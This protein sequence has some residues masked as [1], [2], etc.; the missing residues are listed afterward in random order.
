MN[1]KCRV[2]RWQHVYACNSNNWFD[3]RLVVK[4]LVMN[5][6]CSYLGERKQLR[7]AWFKSTIDMSWTKILWLLLELDLHKWSNKYAC[8]NYLWTLTC[9]YT[10]YGNNELNLMLF[11]G[12][13]P[14][15]VLIL[16]MF[17]SKLFKIRLNVTMN[18][19][20]R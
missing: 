8:M 1:W 10:M 14:L 20:S 19:I 7:K 11:V 13:W 3:L 18:H 4:I 2:Y 12:S 5:I 9:R 17:H 15:C 6:I 16:P